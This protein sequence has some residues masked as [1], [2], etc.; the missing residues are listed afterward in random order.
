MH[1]TPETLD[2][3]DALLAQIRRRA[4]LTERKRGIFYRKSA[5]WLHFHGR[6]GA[7]HADLK[8][9][10]D[11]VRYPANRPAEWRRLL[12]ALDRTAPAALRS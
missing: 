8:V 2:A 11:W 6:P 9:D 10:G 12:A 3:L 1:A 4:W 5:G 7:I